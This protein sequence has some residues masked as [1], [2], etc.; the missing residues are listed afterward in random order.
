MAEVKTTKPAVKAEKKTA[1]APK[2]T[3][4]KKAA[5]AK[6]TAA[7]KPA[8][9]TAKKAPAKKAA[10]V[11]SPLE[12]LTTLVWKKI[13]KKNVKDIPP[14]AV[15]VDVHDVGTFYVA[16]NVSGNPDED[17]QVIP[18]EYNLASG[19]LTASADE[20]KKIAA[21]KYDYIAAVKSGAIAYYGD[22]GKGAI[23]AELFK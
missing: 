13:E 17:K 6:K 4:A 15:Q 10:V 3:A 14:I 22:L 5:P 23:L 1:T 7:K 9:S 16:V 18:A 11:L 12:E 8:A 2:K 19:Y 20:I 21:G